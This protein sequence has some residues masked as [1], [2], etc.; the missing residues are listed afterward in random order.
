LVSL[1]RLHGERGPAVLLDRHAEAAH[2]VQRDLDIGLGNQLADHVDGDRVIARHQRRR[3]Q[4]RRQELAR[5]VAAH[6]H[7]RCMDVAAADAQRRIA[8][9]A[10]V[11]DLGADRVQGVDQVADR[12]LVHARHAVQRVVAADHGQRRRQRTD[13]GA[14]IAHE[15]VGLVVRQMAAAAVH[16]VGAFVELLPLDAERMQAPSMT[17]VSSEASRSWMVVVPSASAA[18]SSVRF[19]MLFEPG[20]RTVP[21][22]MHHGLEVDMLGI[23]LGCVIFLIPDPAAAAVPRLRSLRSMR[24]GR[25]GR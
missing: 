24:S 12:P 23:V 2:Q 18:S 20:R 4:Q 21:A 22:D 8:C 11:F 7:A 15:Q 1:A 6:R 19:E 16:D 17:R 3:H 9:V 13:R 25:A 14:G 5:D 10:G